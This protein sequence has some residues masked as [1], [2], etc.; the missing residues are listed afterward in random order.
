ME[1]ITKLDAELVLVPASGHHSFSDRC[2]V[3]DPDRNYRDTVRHGTHGPI[4]VAAWS[5]S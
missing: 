4:Y 3:Q 1:Y 2:V 5:F